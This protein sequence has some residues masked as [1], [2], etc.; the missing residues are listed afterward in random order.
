MVS[1]EHRQGV[2]VFSIHKSAKELDCNEYKGISVSST[3]S[4]LYGRMIMDLRE[5]EH[6]GQQGEGQSEFNAGRS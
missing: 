4:K 5:E 3:I 6:Y 1:F 2:Y